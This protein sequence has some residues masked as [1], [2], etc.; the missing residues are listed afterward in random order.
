MSVTVHLE[1]SRNFKTLCGKEKVF[2]LL[3]DVPESAGHFPKLANLYDMG[4][5]TYYWEMEKIGLDR[6]AIGAEY[7]CKYMSDK[8]AG[9]VW[10]TPVEGEGNA[11]IQGE[12]QISQN[13]AVGCAVQFSTTAEITLKL[14]A[15]AKIVVAPLLRHE[16]EGMIDTYIRALQQSFEEL[17]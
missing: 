14:P 7:A 17:K 12:W 3:A 11:L 9:R 5:N 15:L 2:Q 1:L 8:K 13:G 10:W 4:E 6:Y 16:F